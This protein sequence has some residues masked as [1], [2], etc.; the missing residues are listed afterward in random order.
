VRTF[1]AILIVFLGML[2]TAIIGT[3]TIFGTSQKQLLHGASAIMLPLY[4]VLVVAWGW[5]IYMAAIAM[6][7]RR[8][9]IA[10]SRWL[11][12]TLLAVVP[13]LF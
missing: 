10:W 5:L 4:V 9:P 12:V 7:E 2:D 3:R 11:I 1:W 8:W 6:R 13:L